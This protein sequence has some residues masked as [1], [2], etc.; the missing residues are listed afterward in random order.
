MLMRRV[1]IKKKFVYGRYN[2]KLPF[3]LHEIISVQMSSKIHFRRGN[4]NP[5]LCSGVI[6]VSSGPKSRTFTVILAVFA[7]QL[8]WCQYRK[9][10]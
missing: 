4:I 10:V 1:C 7:L 5:T 6:A 9:K 2:L 3:I 8:R